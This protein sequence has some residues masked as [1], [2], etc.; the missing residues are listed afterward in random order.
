MIGLLGLGL[1]LRVRL[2]VRVDLNLVKIVT[3]WI[4]NVLF[5]TVFINGAGL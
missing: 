4:E 2:G 3:K 1:G 5:T